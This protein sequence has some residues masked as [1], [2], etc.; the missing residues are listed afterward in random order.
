MQHET[1]RD[2]L[3]VTLALHRYWQD[4]GEWPTGLGELLPNYLAAIPADPVTGT[5]LLYAICDNSPVVYSVGADCDDDGG[6]WPT[7]EDTSWRRERGVAEPETPVMV[8]DNAAAM[9]FG[10]EDPADGDWVLFP[11][12]VDPPAELPDPNQSWGYGEYGGYGGYGP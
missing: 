6:V 7:V 11:I 12:P 2:G 1:Q 10:G 4:R 8:P 5:P 3:L 9:R